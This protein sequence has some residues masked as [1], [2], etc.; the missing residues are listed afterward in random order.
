LKVGLR[1]SRLTDI[2]VT[3]TKSSR[4]VACEWC[5]RPFEPPPGRRGP[6]P[7]YCSRSH[8]QRAYEARRLAAAAP[9]LDGLADALTETRKVL[10]RPNGPRQLATAYQHLADAAAALLGQQPVT[11]TPKLFQV[12]QIETPSRAPLPKRTAKVKK[13]WKVTL[14]PGDPAAGTVLTAHTTEG[15]A[16]SSLRRLEAGWTRYQTKEER[17]RWTWAVLHDPSGNLPEGRDKTQAEASIT[18]R[19]FV[20]PPDVPVTYERRPTP[21]APG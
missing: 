4:R 15:A 5:G 18:G 16:R 21:A 11:V 13:P 7:R 2:L 8:R 12:E 9:D 14:H 17:Q 1:A 6:A 10:R 3:V 19:I 20:R